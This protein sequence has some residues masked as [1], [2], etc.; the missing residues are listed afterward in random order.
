MTRNKEQSYEYLRSKSKKHDIF[1]SFKYFDMNDKVNVFNDIKDKLKFSYK[2]PHEIISRIPQINID[3][4]YIDSLI[5]GSFGIR[6]DFIL[7]SPY[8][9]NDDDSYYLIQNPVLKEKVFKV[10]MVR[11]SGW[12]GAI[13]SAAKKI[14]QEKFE[15]NNLNKSVI[16]CLI[17]YIRLFGTGSEDFRKLEKYVKSKLNEEREKG[18]EE[19]FKLLVTYSLFELG[20]KLKFGGRDKK[21][22]IWNNFKESVKTQKGRCVF[23]PTYFDKISLELINP[24]GKKT[25]AGTTPINYEV[26]PK[27]TKGVLQ[28]LYIPADG[29][30]IDDLA[31]QAY[32]DGLLI[33]DLAKQAYKDY[34]FLKEIIERVFEK[35]GFGAKTKLGWGKGEI[36]DFY[37]LESGIGISFLRGVTTEST[38]NTEG[39]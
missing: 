17:N 3:E 36:Q 22:E 33:N 14:I 29:L 20:L 38:E 1:S 37:P 30:L 23:Y 2:I 21:D 32:A 10:P 7:T 24:H 18:G 19:F 27:D 9:S 4:N 26:V 12:K 13:A 8:Y 25:K 11:G 28:I 34:L 16:E 6:V 35:E 39:R 31:E 5:P 15:N